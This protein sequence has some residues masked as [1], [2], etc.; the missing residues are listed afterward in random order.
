MTEDI[1]ELLR[2]RAVLD[3]RI[4]EIQSDR[5]QAWNTGLDA[6]ASALDKLSR[7]RAWSAGF[8]KRKNVASRSYSPGDDLSNAVIVELG[9]IED[10]YGPRLAVRAE[11]EPAISA[12][13]GHE[14]HACPPPSVITA[15]VVALIERET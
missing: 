7:E 2:Q 11:G 9:F 12:V 5:A 4:A 10:G 13:F 15:L 6:I 1:T 14:Q 8:G 3:N